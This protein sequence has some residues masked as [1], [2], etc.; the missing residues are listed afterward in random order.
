MTDTYEVTSIPYVSPYPF[1]SLNNQIFAYQDD[2]WSDVINLPFDFCFFGD[3]KNEI[4]ASSNGLLSLFIFS[5]RLKLLGFFS[6]R[7]IAYKFCSGIRRK[8]HVGS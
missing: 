1:T 7:Y 8:Y 4:V 6:W 2:N 5:Q 3:V